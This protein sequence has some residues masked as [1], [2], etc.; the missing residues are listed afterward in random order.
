M[1]P[2]KGASRLVPVLV[3]FLLAVQTASAF[4]YPLIGTLSNDDVLF[5]QVQDDLARYH[6]ASVAGAQP[7]PLAFY[8]YKTA[9]GE[10]IFT[11]AS[12]LTLPYDTLA[13]LNRVGKSEA[14]LEG[15]I[16]LL[17]NMPGVF[18]PEK[19]ESELERLM[20]AGRNSGKAKRIESPSGALLFF[21]GERFHPVERAF[22]L[23]ILFHLPVENGTITS[24]YG[25]RI[26]PIS[27]KPHF[28]GG[29]DLAAPSGSLVFAARDGKVIE[30]R[31]DAVLGNYLIVS[32]A[33]G[34]ETVYGHLE[35]FAVEL[36]Q[37][38]T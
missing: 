20:A 35:S 5:R 38:V 16:I 18:I 26:S 25:S 4:D 36:N 27:G 37:S 13:T 31:S 33:G 14:P 3:S 22:F 19:P 8:R 1:T 32:H 12:R 21:P 6:Q 2:R 11:V 15:R 7:P 29:L 24:R 30:R 9:K 10:N 34:Y 17:S 23:D 28:H